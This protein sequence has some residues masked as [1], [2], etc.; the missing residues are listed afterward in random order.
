MW[1]DGPVGLGPRLLPRPVVEDDDPMRFRGHEQGRRRSVMPVACQHSWK[2]GDVGLTRDY[3]HVPSSRRAD[4][5]PLVA[6]LK[7]GV[8]KAAI[9]RARQGARRRQQGKSRAKETSPA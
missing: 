2:T 3:D 8:S 6:Q 9:E 1:F 7:H 5:S 4:G